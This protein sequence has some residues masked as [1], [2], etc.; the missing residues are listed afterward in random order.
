MAEGILFN[1]NKAAN[2][3]FASLGQ[4]EAQKKKKKKETEEEEEKKKKKQEKGKVTPATSQV[5][6][7]DI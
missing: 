4:T 2:V 6:Y 3:A 1:N 5:K 7:V